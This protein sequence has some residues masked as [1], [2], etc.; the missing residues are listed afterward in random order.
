MTDLDVRLD[1]TPIR[2]EKTLALLETINQ[3]VT[4]CNGQYLPDTPLP[5]SYGGVL[6]QLVATGFLPSASAFSVDAWGDG[7]E[8]VPPGLT[9]VVAVGSVNLL[10]GTTG[11]SGSSGTGSG[12]SGGGPPT[13]PGNS[14]FGRGRR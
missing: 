14:S 11:G 5:T 10:T 13:S 3:A 6:S 9:P 7:F 4:S 2:R 8:P 12:S 1:V